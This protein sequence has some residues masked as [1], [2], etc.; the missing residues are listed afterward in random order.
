MLFS[1]LWG[2]FWDVFGGTCF[3]RAAG[4]H[5]DDFGPLLGS[6]LE[7]ILVTFGVP[8]LHRFS[9]GF[10]DSPK[11]KAGLEVRVIYVVSGVQ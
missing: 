10:Q 4:P 8:F 9:Q 11:V 2:S 3:G 1:T 5:F 7:P 6:L